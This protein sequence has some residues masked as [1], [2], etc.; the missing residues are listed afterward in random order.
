MNYD[1]IMLT[2]FQFVAH[3]PFGFRISLKLD[4]FQEL[5]LISFVFS[6]LK[7]ISGEVTGNFDYCIW[8]QIVFS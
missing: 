2:L 8:V 3:V 6:R 5:V 4:V 1:L 7:I